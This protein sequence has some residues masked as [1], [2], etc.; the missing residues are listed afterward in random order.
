ML[1]F[2]IESDVKFNKNLWIIN[3]FNFALLAVPCN[4]QYLYFTYITVFV[5][6]HM[7]PI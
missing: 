4:V 6:G 5:F 3:N 1:K 7:T 2:F